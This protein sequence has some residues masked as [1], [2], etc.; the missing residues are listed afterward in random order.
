[1][2]TFHHRQKFVIYFKQISK[3]IVTVTVTSCTY[4]KY[5]HKLQVTH[6][7]LPNPGLQINEKNK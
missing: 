1:M 5:I 3:K 4:H 2:Y 6:Y 7:T